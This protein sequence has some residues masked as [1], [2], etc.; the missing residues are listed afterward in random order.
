MAIQELDDLLMEK[1]ERN[2]R[3]L[4]QKYY[5]HGSRASR[6][7]ASRLRKQYSLTTVQKIKSGKS[8]KPFLYKPN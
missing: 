2:L 6:L 3:F 7:L 5:E 8:D 1:V 4:K